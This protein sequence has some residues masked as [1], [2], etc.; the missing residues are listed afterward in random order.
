MD[1][2]PAWT[3]PLEQLGT[4]VVFEEGA[5]CAKSL[6]PAAPTYDPAVIRDAVNAH[7]ILAGC[8]QPPWLQSSCAMTLPVGSC[9]S[10]H[11]GD[12]AVTGKWFS[13]RGLFCRSKSLLHI[14]ELSDLQ[15]SW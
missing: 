1:P 5:K 15:G 7:E 2:A 3:T 8:L 6:C 10:V 11:D 14:T 4:A 9:S 13:F 12:G